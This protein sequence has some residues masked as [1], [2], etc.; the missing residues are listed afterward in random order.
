MANIQT[1]KTK[2]Q[3]LIDK[4]NEATG[5]SDVDLTTVVDSLVDGY[6][7]GGTSTPIKEKAVNFWDYNGVLVYSYTITEA[8]ALK[9]LP[10]LPQHPELNIVEC[11]GWSSTLEEVN[12][13]FG[14]LDVFACY[15]PIDR[16]TYIG[17]SLFYL[18]VRN[19][20]Y[21]Y[22]N[23]SVGDSSKPSKIVWGDG[24]ETEV[25]QTSA[26]SSSSKHEHIYLK[27][28]Y[29]TLILLTSGTSR[30]GNGTYSVFQDDKHILK[31]FWCCDLVTPQSYAFKNSYGLTQG[32]L[33]NTSGGMFNSCYA[34]RISNSHK[35]MSGC[36]ATCGGLVRVE[37]LTNN[38]DNNFSYTYSLGIFK[39][40]AT[41]VLTAL[42]PNASTLFL[43]SPSLLNYSAKPYE[44][45]N[46]KIYVHDNLVDSYKSASGWSTYANYI[47]GISEYVDE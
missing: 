44:T 39:T 31:S 27:N 29:V 9:E 38:Y 32:Y 1:I 19:D 45:T 33:K 15:Q 43:A 25:T 10:E 47:K 17:A 30:I 5:N 7:K 12:G 2:I 14:F 20:L 37:T 42:P 6:G 28:G 23:T 35:S 16:K 24:T 13:V 46:L 3:G 8:K 22:M 34:L 11:Y 41:G 36:H 4:G 26:T 40:T 21:V 18:A